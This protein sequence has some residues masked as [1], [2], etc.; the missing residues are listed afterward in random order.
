[1]LRMCSSVMPSSSGVSV[2]AGA[3]QFTVTPA[4]H[5]SFASALEKPITPALAA[6]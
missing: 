2:I 1:M 5:S 3:M 4:S 6:E